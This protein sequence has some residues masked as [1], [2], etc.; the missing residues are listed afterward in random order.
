MTVRFSGIVLTVLIPAVALASVINVSAVPM[1][2]WM[3]LP[4][5]EGWLYRMSLVVYIFLV[6]R[7]MFPVWETDFAGILH[8]DSHQTPR[9]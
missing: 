7:M 4:S 8:H 6:L 9:T 2:S 3:A 1:S 5:V